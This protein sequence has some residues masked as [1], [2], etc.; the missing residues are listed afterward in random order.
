[1]ASL[2]MVYRI[3]RQA[4]T[5]LVESSVERGHCGTTITSWLSGGHPTVA[6]VEVVGTVSFN[7]GRSSARYKRDV[8]VVNFDSY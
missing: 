3:T 5:K 8:K 7:Y 4:G 2:R 6:Q 1:M